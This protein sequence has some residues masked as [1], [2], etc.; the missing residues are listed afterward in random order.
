LDPK[1]YKY[2]KEHEWVVLGPGNT[3]KIGITQHA[4]SQL[5]D[6]VFVDLLP[7]GSD[8]KQYQK[9]GEIESVKAVSE[10]YS[11]VSGKILEINQ[12]ILDEPKVVNDD[13]YGAG[14]F[15][16][17]SLGNPAE[18]D[19]LMTSTEYAAFLADLQEKKHK[20]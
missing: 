19:S 6:I 8:V 9:I 2:T 5:G 17:F 11:P 15:A 18:I 13:C 3:G 12:A 1:E 7:A 20:V 4:Q 16:V 14:W 10:F